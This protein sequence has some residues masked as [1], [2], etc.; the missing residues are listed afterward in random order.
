MNETP[1]G[2]TL[3]NNSSTNKRRELDF[4]PTPS[5]VTEALMSFLTDYHIYPL[6]Y[7]WEPACGDGAMSEVI[8]KRGYT[9]KSSDIR[10]TGYGEGG[11]DYLT[12]P[13][14]GCDSIIT[15]PPFKESERFI[16]KALEIDRPYIT[17]FLLKSQYWHAQRR[18]MLFKQ[19]PP[20]WVLPLNWRPDFMNGERGGAPTME[21]LWTVWI[22][23]E[24]DTRYFILERPKKD[25]DE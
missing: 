14:T 1:Q 21:C 12:A 22:T 11:I 3:A 9:V 8:R 17:A 16:R 4:Y 13:K 2:V 24:Y 10:E 19:H 20:A 5:E 23:G 15:N 25:D 6:G 18:T 7:V